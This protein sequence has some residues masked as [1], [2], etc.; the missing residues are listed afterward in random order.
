[1]TDTGKTTEIRASLLARGW[2]KV[3]VKLAIGGDMHVLRWRRRTFLDEVLFD[4]RRVA[5]TKGLFSRESIFGLEI[6]SGDGA[7]LK[8]V[9]VIDAVPDWTDWLS[10]GR[11]GGVRLETADATIL[12]VGSCGPDWSE[13]FRD[14]YDRS[15][16]AMG[17]ALDRALDKAM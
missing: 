7:P 13:P 12:A 16:K 2:R 11:P 14:L 1:M 6:N 4:D 17:K 8:L 10:D 3:D 5:T 15:V 9:F